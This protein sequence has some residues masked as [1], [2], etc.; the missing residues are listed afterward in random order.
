[1]IIHASIIGLGLGV[2]LLVNVHVSLLVISSC[3]FFPYVLIL[4]IIPVAVFQMATIPSQPSRHYNNNNNNNNILRVAMTTY[5][6]LCRQSPWYQFSLYIS[7]M[8]FLLNNYK[9]NMIQ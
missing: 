9:K 6:R 4:L 8:E 2:Q 7:F 3:V 5:L 1:M